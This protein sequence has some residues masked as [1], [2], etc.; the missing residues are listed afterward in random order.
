MSW[1]KDHVAMF[2]FHL[3]ISISARV[4]AGGADRSGGGVGLAA[5]VVTWM[6]SEDMLA[7]CAC[8]VLSAKW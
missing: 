7:C 4:E 6:A 3:G 8:W 1:K 5:L 2:P